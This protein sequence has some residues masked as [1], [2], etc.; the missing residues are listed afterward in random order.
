MLS[1]CANGVDSAAKAEDFGLVYKKEL[2]LE[3]RESKQETFSSLTGYGDSFFAIRHAPSA[4]EII[5][6]YPAAGASIYASDRNIALLTCDSSNLYLI[7]YEIAWHDTTSYEIIYYLTVVDFLG[8][9]SQS[10]KFCSTETELAAFNSISISGDVI[11]LSSQSGIYTLRSDGTL[12][13]PNED[14]ARAQLIKSGDNELYVYQSINGK[15][16]LRKIKSGTTFIDKSKIT[17]PP[18]YYVFNDNSDALVVL[19]N[20]SG[21]FEYNGNDI[22]QIVSFEQSRISFNGLSDVIG[23]PGAGF[24]CID[25]IGIFMLKSL[26][27]GEAPEKE[28]ITIA[29]FSDLLNYSQPI[30]RFNAISNKYYVV[31][32]NYKEQGR[33]EDEAKSKLNIDIATGNAPDII[34]F[35]N[36]IADNWAAKGFL[37]DLYTLIDSDDTLSRDSL[38]AKDAM[39]F[40]GGLFAIAANFIIETWA[41]SGDKAISSENW[42]VLNVADNSSCLEALPAMDFE[43]ALEQFCIQYVPATV[44]WKA[45]RSDFNSEEFIKV[46]ELSKAMSQKDYSEAELKYVSISSPLSISKLR[47]DAGTTLNF[48]GFPQVSNL[49]GGNI[50]FL[51]RFGIISTS[52]NI[53]AAW[54]IIKYILFSDRATSNV[55]FPSVL[56]DEMDKRIYEY[57]YNYSEDGVPAVSP[58]TD[59]DIEEY[60]SLLSKCKVSQNYDPNIRTIIRDEAARYYDGL[61]TADECA[62]II[63][64]R[65]NLYVGEQS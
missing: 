20:Q 26:E 25:E 13:E 54:S 18:E 43:S 23:V 10:V 50:G 30:S 11:Y 12:S 16:T 19:Q 45:S 57:V 24:L 55:T 42:D 4:E 31:I 27:E 48:V 49:Y 64:S 36:I 56:A 34:I 7:E 17:I 33:T 2:L 1:A 21:I 51:E 6:V 9:N 62:K 61:I 3:T 65:V 32:K 22:K 8:K 15:P 44:D 39:E 28:T 35:N 47:K 60:Y 63:Q 59:S 37:V 5:E 29:A 46:L 14:G 40:N 58:I 52:P 38:L 41:V 53:E